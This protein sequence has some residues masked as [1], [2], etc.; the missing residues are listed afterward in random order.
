MKRKLSPKQIKNIEDFYNYYLQW[1]AVATPKKA[2]LYL[3][4]IH[5]LEFYAHF[6]AEKSPPTGNNTICL[7]EFNNKV[8]LLDELIKFFTEY[9]PNPYNYKRSYRKTES[10]KRL[11]FDSG[12]LIK[13]R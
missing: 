6:P 9:A 13:F 7:L 8:M 1:I 12:K 5:S 2:T 10:W 3:F 11:C 4:D